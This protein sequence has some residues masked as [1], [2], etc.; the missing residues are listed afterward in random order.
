M[1]GLAQAAG[2]LT[3]LPVGSRE[4]EQARRYGSGA[5]SAGSTQAAIPWFPVVGG[6]IGLLL[7]GLWCGLGRVLPYGVA[8]ALV[9]GADLIVT[10]ML[11]MDGLVDTADGLIPPMDRQRRLDVMRDPR[12]G[13]FGVVAA[14]AVLVVRFATLARFAPSVIL[15]C[16]LWALSRGMAGLVMTVM[17]YAKGSGGIANFFLGTAG[18]AHESSPGQVYPAV[19]GPTTFSNV[20][21]H[22]EAQFGGPLEPLVGMPGSSGDQPPGSAPRS[23]SRPWGLHAMGAVSGAGGAAIGAAA[24]LSWSVRGGAEGL[25][26]AVVGFTATSLFGFARLGGFTGDVLGASIVM[27]ETLGLVAAAI[28]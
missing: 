19:G 4:P 1:R 9:V 5:D 21:M 12:A 28:H 27:A 13:A 22:G 25:A 23:R 6:A 15:L 8:A 14:V 24:L 2:F 17:P 10:G 20:E 16:G 3:W 18:G 11:H 26:G 7:G